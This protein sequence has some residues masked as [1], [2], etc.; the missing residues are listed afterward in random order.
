MADPLGSGPEQPE[1][2]PSLAWAAVVLYAL[3]LLAG[4]GW[5]WLR[6]RTGQVTA[7]A[8]GEH[9]LLWSMGLGVAVGLALSGVFAA[10]I[11]HTR[12]F[13]RLERRLAALVGPLSDS[14]TTVLALFS[15][16]GEEFFFRL[17]MQDALGLYWSA[18][19]FGLLHLGPRGTWLWP[20]LAGALGLGFGWMVQA[21]CGLL[22]VTVAHALVNY[23]S[24]RRMERR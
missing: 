18:A 3:L 10:A 17:A 11:R 6:D 21:G 22:S 4:Y 7:T 16:L 8:V 19:I 15:A 14:E 20:V 5:L 2:A 9:G 1:Q 23:I 12:A 13:A 24:L